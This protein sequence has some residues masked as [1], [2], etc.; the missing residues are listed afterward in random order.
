MALRYP[1]VVEYERNKP[2][3]F[4]DTSLTASYPSASLADFGYILIAISNPVD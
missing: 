1:P 3:T 4:T 2:V